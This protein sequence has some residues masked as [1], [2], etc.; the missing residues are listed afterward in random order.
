MKKIL[1]WLILG[2]KGGYN[3]AKMIKYLHDTPSNA[4]QLAENLNLNYRTIT[5]HL[6]VLEEVNVITSVGKKYGKTYFI[7]D[8]LNDNFESFKE[9]WKQIKDD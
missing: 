5:Y 4:H 2:T 6:K 7:S 9:I 8:E 1:T 3:R